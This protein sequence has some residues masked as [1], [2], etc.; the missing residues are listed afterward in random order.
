MKKKRVKG[1]KKKKEKKRCS[2]KKRK[3]KMFTKKMFGDIRMYN[4]CECLRAR[5][6]D[7]VDPLEKIFMCFYVYIYI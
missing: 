7:Q 5:E 6:I 4:S 1:E 3:K 2:K